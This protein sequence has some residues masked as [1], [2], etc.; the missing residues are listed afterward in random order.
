[1]KLR[2]GGGEMK[3]REGVNETR[4]EGLMKLGEGGFNETM[5]GG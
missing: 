3:L 2:E 1:M 4:G 5:G